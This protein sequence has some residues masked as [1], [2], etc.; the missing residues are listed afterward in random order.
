MRTSRQDKAWSVQILDDRRGNATHETTLMGLFH[1]IVLLFSISH[2]IVTLC[3]RV[4]VSPEAIRQRRGIAMARKSRETLQRPDR[5][6]ENPVSSIYSVLAHHCFADI[7]IRRVPV[8]ETATRATAHRIPH[9]PQ[10]IRCVNS[11]EA[12]SGRWGSYR[13]SLHAC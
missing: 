8:D 9:T 7:D 5:R 2:P 13:W 1:R 4:V 12:G 6:R 3:I 10:A 11:L